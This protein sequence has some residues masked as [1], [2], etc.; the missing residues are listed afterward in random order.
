M[1]LSA[2]IVLLLT[3]SVFFTLSYLRKSALDQRAAENR[4][5]LQRYED[6]QTALFDVDQALADFLAKPGSVEISLLYQQLGD[7]KRAADT[8]AYNSPTRRN[9]KLLLAYAP[10]FK[11]IRD[12]EQLQDGKL[13]LLATFHKLRLQLEET[14]AQESEQLRQNTANAYAET[15]A[16]R[17]NLILV[18]GL[19]LAVSLILAGHWRLGRLQQETLRVMCEGTR[20]LSRGDLEY[21]FKD[22]TPD[23]MGQLKFDFN[24]MARQLQKQSEELQKVNRELRKQAKNLQEAHRH[25]DR[26]LSNMSHEL[27]TPLNSIIGFSELLEA[28]AGK[29]PPEKQEAYAKRIL[30][31]AGHLLDLITALL[32]LAKSGAGKL[33]PSPVELDLSQTILEMCDIL[34]PLAE[35]KKLEVKREITPN[36]QI[37]AD[38]RMIRQIFINLFSNAVKYTE[39]GSITVRVQERGTAL[40][41]EIEDTGIGIPEK[42]QPKLFQDFY[43]VESA[44][45][46]AVEGVGIGLALS[47][48]LSALNGGEITFI[49]KERIGSTFTVSF[50]KTAK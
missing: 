24:A 46:N 47:R 17:E 48:R 13:E 23:E 30:T 32:D 22:I 9:A 6:V 35:R 2:A 8:L 14:L 4:E 10:I 25:K 11:R 16:T 1:W 41:F 5:S 33:V 19:L 34:A 7:L 50:V 28:R 37:T 38:A 40:L 12:P 44:D 31:A 39:Q 45:I 29:L 27:R 18:G 42:D 3:F 21:R 15:T 20:A 26:F 36:L 49:S 43:R